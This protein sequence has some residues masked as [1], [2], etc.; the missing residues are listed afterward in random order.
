MKLLP[1]AFFLVLPTLLVAQ[2]K[3]EWRRVFKYEDGTLIELN[4]SK[5]AFGLGQ[6]GRVRFRVV[7]A[8]P[9]SPKGLPGRAYKTHLET[10]E[11][12]CAERRFR[13]AEIILLDPQ[14]SPVYSYKGEMADEWEGVK[15][16]TMIHRVYDPA[17]ALIDEKRHNPDKEP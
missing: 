8:K 17:C 16:K 2:E 10:V 15:P 14:G 9:Q 12:K 6:V 5:V 11:F 4:A 3:D 1:Y 7:W 13:R